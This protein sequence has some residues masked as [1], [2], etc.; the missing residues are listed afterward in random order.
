M[1]KQCCE[2]SAVA[3]GMILQV[4]LSFYH[5]EDLLGELVFFGKR[6]HPKENENTEQKNRGNTTERVH[7]SFSF[8]V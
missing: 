6:N 2:L 1:S 3:D 4:G 7:E 8:L 5:D